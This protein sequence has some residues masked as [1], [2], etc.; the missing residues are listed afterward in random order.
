VPERI[1]FRAELPHTFSDKIDREAL[2]RQS[3][4]S[5]SKS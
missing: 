4:A 2:L 5:A 3:L 1:E